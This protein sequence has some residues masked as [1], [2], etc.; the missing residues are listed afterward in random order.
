MR[1][2]RVFGPAAAL[3]VGLML[4]GASPAGAQE[5]SASVGGVN[6]NVS[7]GNRGVVGGLL[8]GLGL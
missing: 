7:V 5:A 1:R 8:R 2:I 4:A 6:A 3:M